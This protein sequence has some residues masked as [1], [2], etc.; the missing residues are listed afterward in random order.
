MFELFFLHFLFT[1]MSFE[2]TIGSPFA[3]WGHTI[4]AAWSDSLGIL[5]DQ[6]MLLAGT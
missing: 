2:D 1:H 3:A 4:V 5:A 6:R